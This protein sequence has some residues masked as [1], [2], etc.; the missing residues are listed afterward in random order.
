MR[1]EEA[2]ISKLVLYIFVLTLQ[3]SR[4]KTWLEWHSGVQKRLIV[5]VSNVGT[6]SAGDFEQ[7]KIFAHE[8]V[9]CCGFSKLLGLVAL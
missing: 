2:N 6:V 5:E 3:V 1:L 7:V 8:L 9:Y 4:A